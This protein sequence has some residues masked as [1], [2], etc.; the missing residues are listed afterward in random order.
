[1][2]DLAELIVQ[3]KTPTDILEAI[4]TQHWDMEACGCW[5][6]RAGREAGCRPRDGFLPRQLPLPTVWVD[7]ERKL[8]RPELGGGNDD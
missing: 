3:L 4:M 5:V 6:C 2:T 1:M 7:A 8:L